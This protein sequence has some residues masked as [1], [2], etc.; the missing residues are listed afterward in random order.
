MDYDHISKLSPQELYE[1][2]L[3]FKGANDEYYWFY[4]IMSAHYMYVPTRSYIYDES[5]AV[6]ACLSKHKS[7]G[8][9]GIY[10]D[11]LCSLALMYV[12]GYHMLNNFDRAEELYEIAINKGN[13][14]A[15]SL[16]KNMYLC[17]NLNRNDK[18]I[19]LCESFI[20]INDNDMYKD[21]SLAMLVET[22]RIAHMKN[23]TQYVINYF[24]K[25]NRLDKLK[26]IYD[27]DDYLLGMI[28][29]YSK[30][31]NKTNELEKENDELKTH[32]MA[33]PDGKLYFEAKENW[34]K[35]ISK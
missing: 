29:N 8:K 26:E 24:K 6:W 14:K 7:V 23:N 32:I 1:K 5:E 34:N 35:N 17:N 4:M 12:F 9:I 15:L 20:E 2:A 25:I 22:Y 16:L 11:S 18:L 13:F 21:A 19:K 10:T 30:L 31:I 33:S 3:E 28:V 27:I